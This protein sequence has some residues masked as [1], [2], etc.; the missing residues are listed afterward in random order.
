MEADNI[1]AKIRQRRHD[2]GLTIEELAAKAGVGATSLQRYE[3]GVNSPTYYQLFKIA[4]ALSCTVGELADKTGDQYRAIV[5]EALA[6]FGDTDRPREVHTVDVPLYET[7]PAGGWSDVAHVPNGTF[8]VLHH[9]AGEGCVVVKVAGMSMWPTLH[10]G[11]LVLVDT[12]RESPKSGEIIFAMLH[13]ATTLKRFRR[14]RRQPLL[15][16]DNPSY[17]PVEIDDPAALELLGVALRL[18]DRDITKSTG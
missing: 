7:V 4:G 15:I 18:V 5:S 13:G 12:T 2:L 1:G 3:L 17:P 16:A 8:P 14:V 10:D 9:L 6:P 11:D